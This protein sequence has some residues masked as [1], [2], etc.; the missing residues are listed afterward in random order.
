[1]C[2]V[3]ST[4]PEPSSAVRQDWRRTSGADPVPYLVLEA[5]VDGADDGGDDRPQVVIATD[6][7][8]IN[9]FYRHL[10][11]LLAEQGYRAVVPDLFHRVGEARDSSRE[12]AFERRALLDDVQAVADLE[13]VIEEIGGRARRF[14]M[15]GFCLGGT[16]ALLTGATRQEQ[17]TVTY[18]AFP[19]GVPGAKVPTVEPLDVADR[20]TGPVLGFWGRQDYI[21]SDEVDLLEAAL[22]RSPANHEVVWY[23]R[24]GHSFLAGLTEEG[25]DSAEAAADSWRRTLDFL[26]GHLGAPVAA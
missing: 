10:A 21:D 9:P 1:M 11:V 8:G 12:A 16:F 24:A 15:L 17:V 13:K 2:H 5:G 18:Y 22:G 6:I 3:R 14:G 7:Y 4:A 26:R 23:E 25:H 20:I 19:R